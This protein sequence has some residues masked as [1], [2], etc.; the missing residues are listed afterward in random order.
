MNDAYF[1]RNFFVQTKEDKSGIVEEIPQTLDE[2][3]LVAK[4]E[5]LVHT[6]LGILNK[7]ASYGVGPSMKEFNKPPK[8]RGYISPGP[9]ISEHITKQKA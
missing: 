6:L 8:T 1:R 5:G 9:D 7:A 3:E 2:A 4:R